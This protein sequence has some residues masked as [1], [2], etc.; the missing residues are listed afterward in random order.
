MIS[1]DNLTTFSY[2]KRNYNQDLKTGRFWEQLGNYSADKPL[3]LVLGGNGTETEKEANGNSKIVARLLGVFHQDVDL[4]SVSYNHAVGYKDRENSGCADIIKKFFLPRISKNGARLPI[5]EACKGMRLINVFAHCHGANSILYKVIGSLKEIMKFLRY[6]EEEQRLILEQIFAVSY[7]AAYD[8][9]EIKRLEVLSI[10]DETFQQQGIRLVRDFMFDLDKVNLNP[11]DK[12]KLEKMDSIQLYSFM[13]E[14]P[15]CYS[16]PQGRSYRL[17]T[18]GLSKTRNH[19][20]AFLERNENWEKADSAT[21]KGDVVS[22]CI[23]C[24]LCNAV[25]NSILNKNSQELIPFDMETFGQQIED[26][27]RPLNETEVQYENQ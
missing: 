26:I 11:L 20:I 17:V 18:A 27:V 25:A 12:P 6:S 24:A 10:D 5:E 2:I 15:R 8:N 9:E 21:K 16:L 3:V 13:M 14:N 7:G 1:N 4:I 22:K 19:E 23:A